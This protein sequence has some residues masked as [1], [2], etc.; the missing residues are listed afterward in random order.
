MQ[1]VEQ[2]QEVKIQYGARF[3]GKTNRKSFIA[4]LPEE[5]FRLQLRLKFMETKDLDKALDAVRMMVVKA[6]AR[7]S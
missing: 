7:R 5:D 6:V 3:S 2:Q 4:F 1:H